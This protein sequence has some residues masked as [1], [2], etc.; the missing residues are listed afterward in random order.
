M[1]KGDI[2]AEADRLHSTNILIASLSRQDVALLEPYLVREELAREAV[3]IE[4]GR[5]IEH[6]WF[7]EGGIASVVVDTADHG[8]T[9]IGIFG[10][11][12]FSGIPLLLGATASPHRT[13][14]QV[15][16]H[17]GLRIAAAPFMAAV[18][19]S[20]TLRTTLLRYVQTFIVQLA[21]STVSNAHQRIEA[22]LARW[23]LMCHDR[24]DADEIPLTHESMAMMIAAERS[25]VTVSLHVLEGAGMIRSRRGRV[26]ILDR[27][28]LEEL[29][30]DGYGRSEAEYRAMIAPFGK[31]DPWIAAS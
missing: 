4:A 1:C 9:E 5:P 7:P 17:M 12:G 16:G 13:F 24:Y 3:L 23:L 31:T 25:S 14:I 8:M 10:R 28:L 6:L 21:H 22:R 19:Q 30:G 15:D 26:A 2:V 27:N 29:A 20:A 18:D 11:E